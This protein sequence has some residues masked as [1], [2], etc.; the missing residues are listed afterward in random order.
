MP[1]TALIINRRRRRR[2][3]YQARTY[4]WIGLG[5]V[6]IVSLII[7][8]VGLIFSIVYFNLTSDLPSL[9]VLPE[10]LDPPDGILLQ[11]SRL[12][13][14]TGEQVLLTLENPAAPDT[15]ILGLDPPELNYLPANLI[16]ATLATSDPN[17]WQGPGYSLSGLQEGQASRG[18]RGGCH[19]PTP[20]F[21]FLR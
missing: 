15:Q 12:Y 16:T 4:A 2:D 17:F 9:A 14:H 1:D 7:C 18:F 5:C 11:P 19:K 3:S 6:T 8:T 21:G 13:D 20:Q 10:L